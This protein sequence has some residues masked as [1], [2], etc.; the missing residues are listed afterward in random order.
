MKKY[1][2]QGRAAARKGIKPEDCPYPVCS[3]ER[4]NWMNGWLDYRNTHG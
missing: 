4:T 2:T 3:R 1:Y